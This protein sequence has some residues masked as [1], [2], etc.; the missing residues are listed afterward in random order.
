MDNVDN[1]IE[2]TDTEALEEKDKTRQKKIIYISCIIA[3]AVLVAFFAI[4]Y[5]MT[6][7]VKVYTTDIVPKSISSK[8]ATVGTVRSGV[9]KSFYA[10]T[11]ARVTALNVKAGDTVNQGDV[12]A[13]FSSAEID[14]DVALK[15]YQAE[16]AAAVAEKGKNNIRL[17]NITIS[18]LNS[19]IA[20]LSKQL[21]VSAVSA[22][23]TAE[24]QATFL[25]YSNSVNA[26]NTSIADELDDIQG[27]DPKIKKL[28]LQL[29]EETATQIRTALA[30]SENASISPD[31]LKNAISSAL[32]SAESKL[33][34]ALVN[35]DEKMRK[36]LQLALLK[37]QKN[38][39]STQIPSTEEVN[40]LQAASEAAKQA[41]EAALTQATELKAGWIAPF[42]GVVSQVNIAQDGVTT[43][44]TPGIVLVDTNALV[45]D[46][47]LGKYDAGKVSNGQPVK[48][49][50]GKD[51]LDGKVSFVSSVASVQGEEAAPFVP[52][53]ITVANP[54]KRLI[55]GFDVDVDIQTA[56]ADAAMVLP[57]LSL[58]TDELGKYCY[59]YNKEEHT[60]SKVYVDTG[61]V[62]EEY[63]QITVGLQFGDTIILNPSDKLYDGARVRVMDPEETTAPPVGLTTALYGSQDTTVPVQEET[64]DKFNYPNNETQPN[65]VNPEYYQNTQGTSSINL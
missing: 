12:M 6:R 19:E 20:S 16:T 3:L 49:H 7:G 42:T 40:R 28:F 43:V 53:Q 39:L 17:L 27:I 58:R 62:N 22:S 38:I 59:R 2:I 14:A 60:V 63:C 9:E 36:Q 55:I 54:D 33:E 57:V 34:S 18:Q 4:V 31:E 46:V 47:D 41:Y 23:G 37:Q 51:T 21:G 8:I 64:T 11:Q 65:T 29:E 25:G 45:I 5:N 26:V 10:F 61:I 30:A 56:S 48:I 1:S 35:S 15:K 24:F 13:L 52:C 50:V 44:G 32:S